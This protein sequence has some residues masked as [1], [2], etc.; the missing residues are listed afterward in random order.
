MIYKLNLQMFAGEGAGE[1]APAAEPATGGGAETAAAVPAASAPISAGSTLADGTRV[2]NAQVAAALEKQ[3]KR[4]PE[5]RSVYGQAPQQQ[6]VQAAPAEKTIDQRWEEAKKGE[7]AELY[8]RDVQRA[9]QDRFKNQKQMQGEL[10]K[11]E[12]MLKVLRERAGVG[13]NEELSKQILDDDSLYE[14]EANARGMTVNAYRE[15]MAMKQKVQDAEQREANAF[16]EQQRREH[17]NK[18]MQQA[19]QMKQVYPGFDLMQELNNPAFLRMTSKE[20]G[21]SVED[22]YYAIHHKELNPQMMAYGM[23][24]ARQQMGQTI[25]AQRQRPVEGAMKST[26]QPKAEMKVDPRNLTPQERKEI[27]RRV[28]AGEIVSF[29]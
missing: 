29:D 9:I 28:M 4:H 14:D 15:F 10:D 19:E 11:L 16:Q 5:L 23:Q 18:L 22:A 3:M 8:G 21:I 1:A 2:P 17:F 20:V 24:R 13:S 25:Q 12:P 26:V 6:A 27:K 7:F